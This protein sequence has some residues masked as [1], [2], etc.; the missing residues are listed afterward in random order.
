MSTYAMADGTVYSADEPIAEIMGYQYGDKVALT[1]D[2]N[3][4]D[5][6]ET[7]IV[8]KKSGSGRIRCHYDYGEEDGVGQLDLRAGESVNL[9][10]YPEDFGVGNLSLSGNVTV[11]DFAITGEN[12]GIVEAEFGFTGVLTEGSISA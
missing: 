7:N 3:A 12:E 8:G 2:D 11:T 5:T 4:L 6:T 9:N 1:R 10:I